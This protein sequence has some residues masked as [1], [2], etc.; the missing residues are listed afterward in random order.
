MKKKLSFIAIMIAMVFALV[1]FNSCEELGTTGSVSI[2]NTT[3]NTIIVDVSDGN[4]NWVGEKTVYSGSSTT[5]SSVEAGTIYGVAR[6]SG[7]ST[8]YTSS[9][10]LLSVGSTV[11]ITWYPTKKSSNIEPKLSA[12]EDGIAIEVEKT[13]M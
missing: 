9:P 2:Y 13:N 10:R 11:S 5:Y 4:G 3:G 12:T 6:F 8:W 7:Y 1:T